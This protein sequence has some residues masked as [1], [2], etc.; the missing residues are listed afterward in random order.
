MRVL[1]TGAGGFIGSSV[2]RRLLDEGF[3]VGAVTRDAT[4]PRL[5]F[6]HPKLLLLNATLSADGSDTKRIL[7][8]FTPDRCIH[9]AWYAQPGKYLISPE[10]VTCL[11]ASIRLVEA[12]L[13]A[14]CRHV[15]IAGTCAEYLNRSGPLREGDPIGA[16]TLYAASKVSLS[17]VARRLLS[18]AGGSLA[19]SR[20]FFIYGPREDPQRLVPSAI[21]S[22][23]AGRIF[24]AS[25][26][27]QVRDYLHVDDVAAGLVTLMKQSADGV[28]NICSGEPI[29]VKEVLNLIAAMLG[30]TRLLAIGDLPY[31]DSEPDS[32]Y[33][34]NGRMR[35]LGWL[36]RLSLEQ[37]VADALKYW[38]AV[39][40]GDA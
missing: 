34:D 13:E 35:S 24:R 12:L 17:L 22:L 40:E 23:I 18:D 3:E 9:L 28:F 4:V 36:P 37:G 31:R 26:G 11:F 8:E 5:N 15:T 39:G 38:T 2:V 20:L 21:R 14:G 10:N 29:T 27:E 16:A 32:V 1:V 30:R 19:W 25:P 6:R 33:G 7:A